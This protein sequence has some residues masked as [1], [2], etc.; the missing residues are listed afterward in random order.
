MVYGV[1]GLLMYMVYGVAGLLLGLFPLGWG[2]GVGGVFLGVKKTLKLSNKKTL[3]F[4]SD[5]VA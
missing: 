5:L 2:V 1:A 3:K 4:I